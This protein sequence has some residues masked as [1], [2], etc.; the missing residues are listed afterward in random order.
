M[1][2][3]PQAAKAASESAGRMT[4]DGDL[5]DIIR[6]EN[7]MKKL[8]TTGLALSA[9]LTASLGD[10][11]A[12]VNYPWCIIGDSRGIDC[13]FSSREQCSVDGRN[14]GFGGQCIQNPFYNPAL[15]SVV[16]GPVKKTDQDRQKSQR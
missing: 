15:P 1:H 9:V 11:H 3:R 8:I 16:P 2:D 5:P 4:L 7:D 14:R 12:Y 6:E 13:V 10:V